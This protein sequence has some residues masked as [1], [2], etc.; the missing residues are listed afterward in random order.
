MGKIADAVLDVV[1]AKG[2]AAV[3]VQEGPAAL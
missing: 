2:G 1:A 3:G